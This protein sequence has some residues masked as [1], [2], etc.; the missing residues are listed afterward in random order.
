MSG[1]HVPPIDALTPASPARAAERE[2]G[3]VGGLAALGGA[4]E[5]TEGFLS[6]SEAFL[7]RQESGE[8]YRRSKNPYR[9][10]ARKRLHQRDVKRDTGLSN[11][12]YLAATSGTQKLTVKI[13]PARVKFTVSDPLADL[14]SSTRP[15]RGGRGV[16]REFSDGARDRLADRA[17][18]LQVM[19]HEPQIMQTLTCPGEWESVY[20]GKDEPA[21]RIFKQ[22]QEAF[23]KRL[24][25]KLEKLGIPSWSALWFL[26]F[27]QRGAPHLHIIIFG[28]V[29]SSKQRAAL[30]S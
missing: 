8:A 28:C 15:P 11:T 27:Q 10:M 16:V 23:R 13:T 4:A 22:H 30:R 2:R 7:D 12:A 1:P 19:G 9:V 6:R 5:L 29:I 24:D 18:E 17:A 21:G 3:A 26:E 14:E 20:I 25:R